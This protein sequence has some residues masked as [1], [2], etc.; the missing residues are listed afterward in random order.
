MSC[1]IWFVIFFV[2]CVIVSF[3]FYRIYYKRGL[4]VSGDWDSRYMKEIY[5]LHY[6]VATGDM[7]EVEKLTD[8]GKDINLHENSF[9]L[10][11]PLHRAVAFNEY[12]IAGLLIMKGADLD[13]KDSFGMTPVTLAALLNKLDFIGLFASHG[14]DLNIKDKMNRTPLFY[15]IRHNNRDMVEIIRKHGGDAE[16]F[17][18]IPSRLIYNAACGGNL[19]HVKIIIRKNP[20]ML[21]LYDPFDFTPL[22]WAAAGGLHIHIAP[23]INN[24]I[25]NE[26]GNISR[27]YLKPRPYHAAAVIIE[28]EKKGEFMFD[29]YYVKADT[30]G[31]YERVVEFL[32]AEGADVN[33]RNIFGWTP[34][35]I[36]RMKGNFRLAR[37]IEE[38]GG[39]E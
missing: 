2:I 27:T 23:V 29:K 35:K 8:E 37:I 14:A 12:L 6:A 7:Q 4:I 5:P 3:I 36:A 20:Y 31:S 39:M 17:E 9:H 11:T 22:H 32:I 13:E 16:Y 18:F 25:F 26:I 38:N 1:A 24:K 34:L 15:A 30:P 19:E 33:A 28:D 10:M 21:N